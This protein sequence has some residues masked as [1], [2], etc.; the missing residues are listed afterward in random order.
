MQK[1]TEREAVPAGLT[2]AEA[3]VRLGCTEDFVLELIVRGS[4]VGRIWP[5]RLGGPG[6]RVAPSALRAYFDGPAE[7]AA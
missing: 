1:E 3:A 4:L 6:W 7:L 5:K 2:P